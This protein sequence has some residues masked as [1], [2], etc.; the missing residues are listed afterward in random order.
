M[1]QAGAG[2]EVVPPLAPEDPPVPDRPAVAAP[3]ALDLAEE[4]TPL[5]DPAPEEVPPV[6]ELDSEIVVEDPVPVAGNRTAP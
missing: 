5:P 3:V 6:E 4:E 2:F 1:I